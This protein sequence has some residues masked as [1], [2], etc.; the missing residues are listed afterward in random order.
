MLLPGLAIFDFGI[1]YPGGGSGNLITQAIAFGMK[2][3]Q[4]L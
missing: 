2:N 3:V 4:L 1:T